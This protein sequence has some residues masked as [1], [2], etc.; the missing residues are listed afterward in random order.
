MGSDR[1]TCARRATLIGHDV[2]GEA[3]HRRDR[4]LVLRSGR[5]VDALFDLGSLVG[6][7]HPH[8]QSLTDRR[9]ELL[10]EGRVHHDLPRIGAVRQ[11]AVEH[12][13]RG[14]CGRAEVRG[15]SSDAADHLSRPVDEVRRDVT[16]RVR[17]PHTRQRESI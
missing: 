6:G 16:V 14:I 10:S 13:Q 7:E 4:Q 5:M 12:A 3:D 8:P 11:F 17:A 1:A 2:L 15:Q 9:C